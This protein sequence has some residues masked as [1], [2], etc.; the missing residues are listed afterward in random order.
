MAYIPSWLQAANPAEYFS[1]GLPQGVAA[2][3]AQLRAQEVAGEQAQRAA[4]LS[5]QQ[6]QR[7][8]DA[9]RQAQQF[10]IEQQLA[11]QRMAAQTQETQQQQAMSEKYYQ[12][13]AK[14]AADKSSRLLNYQRDIANKVDPVEAA[15]KWFPDTGGITAQVIRSQAAMANEG[16]RSQTSMANEDL[17]SQT[18]MANA[19][20]RSQTAMANAGHRGQITGLTP[21]QRENLIRQYAAQRTKVLSENLFMYP[22]IDS[23]EKPP[24]DWKGSGI[25]QDTWRSFRKEVKRLDDEISKLDTEQEGGQLPPQEA[26]TTAPPPAGGPTIPDSLIPKA[27]PTAA[28]AGPKRWV[29]GVWYDAQ[30]KPLPPAGTK[31][32]APSPTGPSRL[33]ALNTAYGQMVNRGAPIY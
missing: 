25:Q 7:Q 26:P 19:K 18:S 13:Q 5:A 29:N 23:L 28:A 6:A 2:G 30:G 20:L 9:A 16:L 14:Q 15:M 10:L 3:Q 12:L 32:T 21:Y 17:R 1:R 11:Q 33:D 31:P 4:E 24:K 8:E 27:A 22:G